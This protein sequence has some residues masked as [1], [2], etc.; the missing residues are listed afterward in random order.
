MESTVSGLI[1]AERYERSLER[2]SWRKGLRALCWDTRVGT[3]ELA[4]PQVSGVDAGPSEDGPFRTPFP[5]SL[6]K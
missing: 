3:I 6:V 4:I 2:S 5:R 1:G